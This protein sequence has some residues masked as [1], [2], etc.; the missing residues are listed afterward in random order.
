MFINT[1]HLPT[2]TDVTLF[3]SG[4]VKVIPFERHFGEGERDQGLKGKLAQPD[5]LSGILN[6]CLQGLWMIGE[7]GFEPP[8]AVLDATDQYRQDSDKISRFIADEL[9][10]GPGYE[11]KTVDAYERYKEWCYRNGFQPGSVKTWRPDMENVVKISAKRPK[12]GGNSTN[13]ILGY[14]LRPTQGPFG[15]AI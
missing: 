8:A 13:L 11:V 14:R 2:V 3:S 9:E 15:R 5:S 6:W 4:R 7:T 12:T 10:A 1:N